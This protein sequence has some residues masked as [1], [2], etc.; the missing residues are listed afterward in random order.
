MKS[1]VKQLSLFELELTTTNP[2]KIVLPK[3]YK[4]LAAFHKYWGKK[5]IECLSFLIENLKAQPNAIKL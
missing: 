4:G 2:E 3:G 1:L 5:P